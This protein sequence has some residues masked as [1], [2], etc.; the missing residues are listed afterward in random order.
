MQQ[1][2]LYL[3]EEF[4]QV[5]SADCIDEVVNK[6]SAICPKAEFT[7]VSEQLAVGQDTTSG[8]KFMIIT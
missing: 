1:F 7:K 3:N 5:F 8:N 4:D 2:T 6:V